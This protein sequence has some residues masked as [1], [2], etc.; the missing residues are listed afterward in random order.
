MA[1]GTPPVASSVPGQRMRSRNP[2]SAF[3]RHRNLTRELVRNEILGRYRGA[4]FG[5]LWSLLS[6]FMMLVVYTIAFGSILKGR[7]PQTGDTHAEFGLVIFVGIFVHGF[8]GECFTRAPR[9]MLDN[10][11]YVKRVVFPLDILPWT[12]VLAAI[13]HL[14]MNVLVFCLLSFFVYRQLSPLVVLLPVVLAP[15]VLITVAVSWLVASLGVYLRDIAQVAPVA[16][17]AMFFLSSAIVPVDA[18]PEKYQLV[19]KLNPL[20]FFIDQ[21]R[22]VALWGRQPDWAALAWFGLGGLVAVFAAH[23]WFRRTSKGFADVL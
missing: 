21:A 16:S 3:G 8:F 15:L 17:T 22:E 20:T 6:P 14:A 11:N 1:G 18:V 12:M 2:F 5:M 13:F 10:A 23:A 19:F 4:T 9:L 7:W